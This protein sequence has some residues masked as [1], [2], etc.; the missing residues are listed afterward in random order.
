MDLREALLW[1]SEHKNNSLEVVGA[2]SVLEKIKMEFNF[3]LYGSGVGRTWEE[4]RGWWSVLTDPDTK[5]QIPEDSTL[6]AEISKAIDSLDG[7]CESGKKGV[8]KLVKEILEA[9]VKP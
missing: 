9:K 4:V 7:I 5:F 1:C 2:G 6:P 3:R 8:R